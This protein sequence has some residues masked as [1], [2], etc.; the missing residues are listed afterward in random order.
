MNSRAAV[1]EGSLSNMEV[2]VNILLSAAVE[3]GSPSNM[4][5]VEGNQ[6]NMGAE[7]GNPWWCWE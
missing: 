2:G 5:E 1:E 6:S 4:V 7:V 3:G